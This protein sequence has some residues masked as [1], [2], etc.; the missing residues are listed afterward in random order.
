MGIKEG[1]C[2]EELGVIDTTNESLNAT[3]NLMIRWL[4]E[5]KGWYIK[6]HQSVGSNKCTNI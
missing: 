1:P 6:E 5:H 4:T 2:G 3:A